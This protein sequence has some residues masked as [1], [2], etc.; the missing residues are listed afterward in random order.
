MWLKAGDHVGFDGV[1]NE[2]FDTTHFMTLTMDGQ[3]E[4][5][6]I[7]T[8]TAGTANTVDVVFGLHRQIVVNR[9]ADGLHV[10]T[11]GSNVSRHQNTDTA[12]LQFAQ[13]A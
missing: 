8:S 9:V 13:C 11:A 7:A 6:A 5:I 2:V 4:S 1:T 3:C 12:V 10:N